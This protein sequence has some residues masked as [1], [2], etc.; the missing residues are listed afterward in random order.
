M[1]NIQNAINQGIATVGTAMA[2]GEHLSEQKKT[3][4]LDKAKT[5]VSA[6]SDAIKFEEQG[7]A[8]NEELNQTVDNLNANIDETHKLNQQIISKRNSK[9]Q[10]MSKLALQETQDKVIELQE[11][12]ERLEK[13]KDFV[14]N[15]IDLHKKLGNE[16]A[17]LFNK[18]LGGKK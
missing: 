16:M 1:G 4:E 17:N 10:F 14:G 6:L 13:Q 3:H 9:G 11:Q 18:E 5:K 12:R 2:L 15:K 8:L 7:Q